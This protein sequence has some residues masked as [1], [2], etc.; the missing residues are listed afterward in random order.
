MAPNNLELFYVSIPLLHAF[1]RDPTPPPPPPI[2]VSN[3]SYPPV[4]TCSLGLLENRG[5]L[6]FR[7]MQSTQTSPPKNSGCNCSPPPPSPKRRLKPPP[8]AAVDD[9]AGA[10]CMEVL[11]AAAGGSAHLRSLDFE[12]SRRFLQ[13]CL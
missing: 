5:V 6:L 10:R 13:Y 4:G 7:C 8:P 2:S 1:A 9:D 11:A 3:R 12:I